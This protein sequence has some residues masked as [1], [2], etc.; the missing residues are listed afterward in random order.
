MRDSNEKPKSLQTVTAAALIAQFDQLLDTRPTL[1]AF[2]ADG[3]L[4]SGDVSDDVFLDACREN[5]LLDDAR[6][7]LKTLAESLGISGAGNASEIGLRLLDASQRGLLEESMLFAS[8]TWC[9]AGRTIQELTD[10][11]ATVLSRKSLPLRLR[12]ELMGVLEWAARRAVRCVVV[13]A[14]P[15]PIVEWGAAQCGFASNLVIGTSPMILDGVISDH[16]VEPVPVSAH[17]CE[18]L[19]RHSG[20]HRVLAAF[21]DSIYDFEMLD[22]AEIAV[23]VRPKPALHSRLLRTSRAN[24]LDMEV[25][26]P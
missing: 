24:V 15:Q 5:W 3:T 10:H 7:A 1:L 6:L 13:S 8:M 25:L 14:S 4:W 26:A 21:G 17:K 19:K 11:A 2:D 18:C 20:G 23:A 16:L 12:T 9:Y 22:I